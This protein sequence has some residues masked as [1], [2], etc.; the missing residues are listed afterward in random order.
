MFCRPLCYAFCFANDGNS[1]SRDRIDNRDSESK[2]R[3][4]SLMLKANCG[5]RELSTFLASFRWKELIVSNGSTR[6]REQLRQ[7]R[8]IF[9]TRA[10]ASD[11][12]ELLSAFVC[13]A[14]LYFLNS[15][16]NER[17]CIEMFIEKEN[18][19]EDTTESAIKAT[20]IARMKLETRE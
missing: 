13:H 18:R 1:D 10:H 2:A 12:H 5:T 15:E 4:E 11:R 14:T 7:T 16:W 20:G 6:F 9:Y 17:S 19:R 3:R 8:V